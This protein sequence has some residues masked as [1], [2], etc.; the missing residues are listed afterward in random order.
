M[1]SRAKPEILLFSLSKVDE[2]T[3]K[4]TLTYLKQGLTRKYFLFF[5]N[6][7]TCELVVPVPNLAFQAVLKST[8]GLVKARTYTKGPCF[9][10]CKLTYIVLLF[11]SY[12]A[13][14]ICIWKNCSVSHVAVIIT[15]FRLHRSSLWRTFKMAMK[16]EYYCN[17]V[18]KKDKILN[19]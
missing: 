6:W 8:F 5:E 18:K 10:T 12:A 17:T 16:S 19:F 14:F 13:Q 11:L 9:K 1:R 3:G 7:F 2:S 4:H 15:S